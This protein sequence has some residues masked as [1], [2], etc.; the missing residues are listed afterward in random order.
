[1]LFISDIHGAARALGKVCSLDETVVILGDLINLTDYRTGE[2][3]V[4]QVLGLDL[5]RSN[6]AARARGDYMGMRAAWVE[7]A[8]E[9][10]ERIRS[11]I[12]EVYEEQYTEMLAAMAG[13][14]GLVIHGNVDRPSMMVDR[15]PAGFSYAHGQV[16]EIDGFSLGLIGGGK[17]TPLGAEGEI[18]DAEM[19]ELLEGLGAVDVLCTHIPPAIRPLR[20]DVIT[21]RD[22]RG[23]EQILAYIRK[24]QPRYHIYGDIH[25]P[26]ASHWRIGRTR[27]VNAGYFRATGR[28]LRLDPAGLQTGRVG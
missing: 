27:C 8:G 26:Q 3:A 17:P 1:M 5:A 20:H 11:A 18:S 19:E 28:Y 4:A 22:E 2:G 12:V 15:L 21:D 24:Y 6:A 16:V 25:Q 7:A 14:S 13:G 10:L 23:S 9:D